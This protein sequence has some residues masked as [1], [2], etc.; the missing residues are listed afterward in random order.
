MKPN[1]FFF[2]LIIFI[3]CQCSDGIET[4]EL[5]ETTSGFYT[6]NTRIGT[7]FYDYPLLL[8]TYHCYSI[9][10][11]IWLEQFNYTEWVVPQYFNSS[12]SFTFSTTFQSWYMYTSTDLYQFSILIEASRDTISFI[13]NMI[14]NAQRFFQINDISNNTESFRLFNHSSGLFGL[15]NPKLCDGISILYNTLNTMKRENGSKDGFGIDFKNKELHVGGF[16]PKE[17]KGIYWGEK[18]LKSDDIF[19]EFTLFHFSVC[20]ADLMYNDTSFLFGRI[21]TLSKCLSIPFFLVDSKLTS[22]LPLNCEGEY[23]RY[24][25]KEPLDVDHLPSLI[26]QLSEKGSKFQIP[27]KSLYLGNDKFCIITRKSVDY[28]TFGV[29]AMKN[30]YLAVNLQSRRIG[31]A[32][33]YSD[34]SDNSLCAIK[35]DC[36]GSQIYY[37]PNNLCINP[38]CEKWFYSVDEETMT[39]KVNLSFMIIIYLLIFAFFLVEFYIQIQKKKTINSIKN[40]KRD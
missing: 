20:G 8:S 16:K 39:C 13:D 35:P 19:Y 40:K 31:F 34:A 28:F 18:Q 23:C 7:P 17:G 6:V 37:P 26:F 32:D 36:F 14:F 4:L 29:M 10:A 38:D 24:V 3:K 12:K 1:L 21:D 30:L 33:Y 11:D 2:I 5:V 22:W 25:G 9:V 15:G 27:L